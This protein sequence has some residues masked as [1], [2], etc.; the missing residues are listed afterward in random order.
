MD[1]Y[2]PPALAAAPPTAAAAAAED[3]RVLCAEGRAGCSCDR[4]ECGRPCTAD[5]GVYDDDD[6]GG[7][8]ELPTF[9]FDGRAAFVAL[10]GV[11]FLSFAVSVVVPVAV[12]EV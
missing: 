5:D 4:G 12:A 2:G 11:A 1:A 3:G 7:G 8:V 10:R 6:D 9:V